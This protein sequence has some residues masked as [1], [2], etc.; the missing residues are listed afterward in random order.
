MPGMHTDGSGKPPGGMTPRASRQTHIF[1]QQNGPT[2]VGQVQM[3]PV[4]HTVFS[5]SQSSSLPQLAVHRPSSGGCAPPPAARRQMRLGHSKAGD[6]M[7]VVVVF[8]PPSAPV[9]S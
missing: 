7:V 9:I 4:L 3:K 8:A 6:V 1:S 5:P 2:V